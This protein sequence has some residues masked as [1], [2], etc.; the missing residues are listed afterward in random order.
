[1]THSFSAHFEG[2]VIVP[3]EPIQLPVGQTFQIQV[4]L[5]S[6]DVHPFADLLQF[7]EDVPDLPT[8][9]SFQLDHYLYGLPKKGAPS[10]L[11]IQEIWVA[12]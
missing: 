11:S 2:K 5:P 1:M 10:A 4:D 7:A 12:G 8:D 6:V 9:L 3:N